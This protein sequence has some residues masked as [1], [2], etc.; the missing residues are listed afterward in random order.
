VVLLEIDPESVAVELKGEAPR[1]IDVHAVADGNAVQ[2]VKIE[3]GQVQVLRSPG[4]VQ[5]VKADQN[6]LVHP[7]IDLARATRLPQV[8][9]GFASE[10]LNHGCN[11][12]G[13]LTLRQLIAYRRR[14]TLGTRRTHKR[15]AMRKTVRASGKWSC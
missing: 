13:L 7:S 6:A 5:T 10:R 15:C 12:S 8:G 1:A 11:V 9:K 3:A 2:R 4:G 14:A